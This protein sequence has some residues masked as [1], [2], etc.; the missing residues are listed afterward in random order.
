M[1][2]EQGQSRSRGTWATAWALWAVTAASGCYMLWR[3]DQALW[4][5]YAVLAVV[6]AAAA[7]V[8]AWRQWQ[9]QKLASGGGV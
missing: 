5:A 1:S 9:S 2:T 3:F 6:C 4:Q 7:P 8:Q